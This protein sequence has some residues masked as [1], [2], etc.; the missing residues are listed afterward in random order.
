MAGPKSVDTVEFPLHPE[1]ER[2]HQAASHTSLHVE[3]SAL[4][5]TGKVRSN[6]ED[7]YLVTRAGRSLQTLMTNLPTG[8]IPDRFDSTGFVMIVA[9]GMG[10]H[11]GGEVASRMAIGTLVQLLLDVPDWIM[12]FDEANMPR[13]KERMTSYYRRVDQALAAYAGSHEQ[14]LGMGTTMTVGSSIGTDL[15]LAHVGDCRCYLF[16][17]GR[18][19]QLTHD[20]TQ[21]QRLLDAG[22]MQPEEAATSRLRNVL[23]QALGA[24]DPSLQ[25]E[26]QRVEIHAGD[27]L[28]LCTDGLTDMI[29]DEAIGAVLERPQPPAASCTALVDL[30]LERGGRDNV[31]VVVADYTAGSVKPSGSGDASRA[32][33]TRTPGLPP[34]R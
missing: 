19:R 29:D 3:V 1:R 28:L 10:G 13:L 21:A 17:N 32:A 6:N 26:M 23:T 4:T 27:R 30:A 7:H 8:D 24:G 12:S 15:F 5:H 11:A 20:Q 14:L 2:Q 9:D 18:L 16:R 33:T 34:E 31:T 22:T 25:V